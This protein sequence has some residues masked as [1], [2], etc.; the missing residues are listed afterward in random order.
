MDKLGFKPERHRNTKT[1]PSA[2]PTIIP[3]LPPS[4]SI[5]CQYSMAVGHDVAKVE[6]RRHLAFDVG[7][8]QDEI[9]NDNGILKR[10]WSTSMPS[11]GYFRKY[12]HNI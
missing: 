9:G 10:S 11:S 3:R 6:P 5:P 7:S 4:D 2:H 12:L 1:L 8:R